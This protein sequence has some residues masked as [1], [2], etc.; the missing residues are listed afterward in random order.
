[1]LA[2][3]HVREQGRTDE[4]ILQITSAS[5]QY[6]GIKFIETRIQPNDALYRHVQDKIGRGMGLFLAGPSRIVIQRQGDDSYRIYFGI[7]APEHFVNTTP[8]LSNP[9]TTRDQLL[10]DFF[11]DWAEELK[12]YIRQSNNFRSWPLY[13]LPAE[14]LN[15]APVPGITLA[16]DAAHLSVPNGEGVNLAMKDALELVSKLEQYGVEGVDIAVK[17]YEKDMF[18]RGK[19]HIKDGESMERLMTHPGGAKAIVEGFAGAA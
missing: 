4:N 17:E 3:P 5:P 15:W 8:D 7:T 13:Q 6:T 16:G 9:E 10:R 11:S 18:I 14:S 12:D 1:M 2:N 19:D